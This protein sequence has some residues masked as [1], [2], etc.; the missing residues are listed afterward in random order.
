VAYDGVPVFAEALEDGR[1]V[2]VAEWNA[3]EFWS[4]SEDNYEISIT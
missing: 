1:I 3:G 4:D 2:T